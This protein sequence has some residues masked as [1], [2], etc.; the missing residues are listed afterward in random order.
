[1]NSTTPI[2]VVTEE[3]RRRR[4]LTW[5]AAGAA[6]ALLAAGGSTYALWKDGEEFAGGKITTGNL[7]IAKVG[8]TT[9]WDM[10]ADRADATDVIPGTGAGTCAAAGAGSGAGS[11]APSGGEDP[12]AA[13]KSGVCAHAIANATTWRMVPEDVVGI[14]MT[15]DVTLE[16]DNL[17]ATLSLDRS[18]VTGT[19]TEPGEAPP[20]TGEDPVTA[21]TDP[22]FTYTYQVYRAGEPLLDNPAPLPESASAPLLTLSATVDGQNHGKDDADTAAKTPVY[23]MPSNKTA[24]KFTVLV[25][26]AFDANEQDRVG[27]VDGFEKATLV[28]EQVRTGGVGQFVAKPG[29]P[30]QP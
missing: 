5:V 29:Q 3:R 15:A 4:G 27:A 16:G 2:V 17:V 30:A 28:L 7:D 21:S 14:A 11:V 25:M 18:A 9:F 19:P 26:A 1:M 22:E 8:D 24:E 10:S 6:V 20:Q 12:V 13:G 23:P